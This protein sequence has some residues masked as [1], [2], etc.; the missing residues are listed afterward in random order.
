MYC[1]NIFR[2]DKE[3]KVKADPQSLWTNVGEGHVPTPTHNYSRLDE[4]DLRCV[5]NDSAMPSPFDEAD[6][7]QR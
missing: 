5:L 2:P 4:S 6:R 3:E 1:G 7:D